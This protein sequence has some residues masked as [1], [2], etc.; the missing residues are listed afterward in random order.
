MLEREF[1]FS[2][3]FISRIK[4]SDIKP[5][6]AIVTLLGLLNSVSLIRVFAS[7]NYDLEVQIYAVAG[8][9]FSVIVS[10]GMAYLIW[11]LYAGGF[12]TLATYLFDGDGDFPV[13][14]RVVGWGF[15]GLLTGRTVTLTFHMVTGFKQSLS[16]TAQV[17]APVV[18]TLTGLLFFAT[19][20]FWTI[21]VYDTLSLNIKESVI[22]VVAPVAFSMLVLALP[23]LI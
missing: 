15:I 13:L 5:P 12:Y 7:T 18:G 23:Y 9:G 14:L 21:S 8:A 17:I 3:S 16:G 2:W 19:V 11:L 20:V 6:L 22:T 10:V 4:R 1:A